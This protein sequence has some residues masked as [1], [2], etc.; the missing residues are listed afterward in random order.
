[1]VATTVFVESTSERLS[2]PTPFVVVSVMV[3]EIE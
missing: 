2:E 3:P 1:V